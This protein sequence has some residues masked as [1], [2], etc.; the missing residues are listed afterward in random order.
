MMKLIIVAIIAIAAPLLLC[1][2]AHAEIFNMTCYPSGSPYMV[3]F[4]TETR[5]GAIAGSVSG[6]VRIYKAHDVQNRADK[7]MLYVAMTAEG[8]TR[9]L[10]LAFD[11]S[12]SRDLSTLRAKDGA[13]DA[14]DRCKFEGHVPGHVA[15]IPLPQTVPQTAMGAAHMRVEHCDNVHDYHDCA[16]VT[17]SGDIIVSDR[18]EFVERT[19]GI[20]RAQVALSGPGG[21]VRAAINIGEIIHAKGWETFVPEGA[22]CHSACAYIWAAGNPHTMG[23]GTELAWHS[24]YLGRDDQHADGNGNALLGKYLGDM[25]YSYDEIDL[26]IG[27]DPNDMRVVRRDVD[28]IVTKF[29]CRLNGDRCATN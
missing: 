2:V 14:R 18:D 7:H 26:M 23:L 19:E 3:S 1:G 16:I 5:I 10:Y 29:N 12:G 20:V 6:H 24:G 15:A 21:A 11:Y 17:I 22:F 25:G 4:N 13:N 28:G 9:I 8:Q 27:T